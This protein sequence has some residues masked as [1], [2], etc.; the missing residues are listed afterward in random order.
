MP[1]M[2]D[3][4]APGCDS[5][6]W[7]LPSV[8][9]EVSMS[10]S[11][12][13]AMRSFRWRD[14][15]IVKTRNAF[16]AH[17]S[18]DELYS[19]LEDG[20]RA[21]IQRPSSYSSF[22]HDTYFSP[23]PSGAARRAT[24]WIVPGGWEQLLLAKGDYPGVW[25]KYDLTSAYLWALTFGLPDPYTYRYTEQISGM[26][27]GCYLMDC[28]PCEGA[29]Y[30]YDRG[31]ILPILRDE[32]DLYGIRGRVLYGVTWNG[33][34]DTDPMLRAIY[35]WPF[36]KQVA[37]SYWGR[38]AATAPL[39]CTSYDTN[40]KRRTRWDMPASHANTI[41]AHVLLSR[42]RARLYSITKLA[43]VARVYVD[44]VIVDRPLPTG[45]AVGSW[46]FET[47][48]NGIR[49]ANLHH[50]TPLGEHRYG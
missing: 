46:R 44:S 25:Y 29:P 13:G 15:G 41:W 24:H 5:Y 45:E 16:T 23:R 4:L 9:P 14:G 43:R 47:A 11:Y 19:L 12:N 17:L 34:M 21:G 26:R 10:W 20:A 6:V 48:F 22:F 42:V 40:G 36:W 8:S 18:P 30:P 1:L 33:Q 7:T 49:I 37:R 28:E 2:L 39:E 35:R 31:G 50:I 27:E 32:V 38:W 3:T